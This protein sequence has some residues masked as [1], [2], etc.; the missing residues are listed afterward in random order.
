MAPLTL[1]LTLP[2]A[3]AIAIALAPARPA[4][5]LTAAASTAGLLLAIFV[6]TCFDPS[7]TSI[8]WLHEADWMPAINAHYRVGVDGLSVLFVPATELL[9][10]AVLLF[11][12]GPGQRERTALLLLLKAA[13]LGIFV[14][15]DGLLFF[16]F[17]E[18][19]LVPTWFLIARHGIG[20]RAP[21]AAMQYALMLLLAGVPVLLA[22]V[23]RGSTGATFDFDLRHWMASPPDETTQ[24]IVYLL[25]LAGFAFK[26]PLVPFHTWLPALAREGAPGV[27]AT[28]VGLKVGAFAILRLA[29]PAAP[30]AAQ[31]LHWLLAGLG[32]G[33][34]VF[35]ALASLAQTN[36]RGLLA[37]ASVSHVGLV[38]L[39]LSSFSI[40]GVRGAMMQ[41]LNFS[42]ASAVLF[43][44]A[45]AL[46]RRLGTN[47][48][49]QLGGV[50][51][52]MPLLASFFVLFV[53]A[54]FGAPGT[55]GFPAELT[56]LFAIF[57]RH[58]GAALAALAAAGIGAA[59]ALGLVRRAFFGPAN[60]PA[61]REAPDL[62]RRE[63]AVALVLALLVLGIG[64]F[65][66]PLYD[67]LGAAARSWAAHLPAVR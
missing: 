25:L 44:L 38:V 37:Y 60:N 63:A 47:E 46:Q 58:A 5:W 22:L 1:L 64:F 6:A 7:D 26:V 67:F 30:E 21:E 10:A 49:G 29:V 66:G 20:V 59:A 9:F 17:W 61:V 41:L 51:G 15:L 24:R 42:L 12:R 56:M 57:D 53:F 23:L 8:Q 13:T 31:S 4:R 28:I 36:L 27:L 54:G 45:G 33:A 39:A 11:D 16:L 40:D 18:L 62:D 34:L 14:A 50:A 3:A 52:P 2:A 43:L 55:S 48:V 32:A 65:P 19:A 35:G